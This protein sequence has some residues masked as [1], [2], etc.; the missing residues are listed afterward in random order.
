LDDSLSGGLG[1]ADAF[2]F[3]VAG[4]SNNGVYKYT[5][6]MVVSLLLVCGMDVDASAYSVRVPC[7][8][9]LHLDLLVNRLLTQWLTSGEL[10]THTEVGLDDPE[11]IEVVATPTFWNNA[12]AF[13]DYYSDPDFWSDAI[14]E[15]YSTALA[16]ERA[17]ETEH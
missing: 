10:P 1:N 2:I 5:R 7:S 12:I 16:K 8:M 14:H 3:P 13:Q 6:D 4:G 17:Y 11:A 9:V 15:Y